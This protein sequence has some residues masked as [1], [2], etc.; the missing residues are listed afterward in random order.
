MRA[1]DRALDERLPGSTLYSKRPSRTF[2]AP[3]RSVSSPAPMSSSTF[4]R[5]TLSPPISIGSSRVGPVARFSTSQAVSRPSRRSPASRFESEAHSYRPLHPPYAAPGG[6]VPHYH[7]LT[8]PVRFLPLFFLLAAGAMRPASL[9][10]V[11]C[12]QHAPLTLRLGQ[13][14][15]LPRS[16]SNPTSSAVIFS[17]RMEANALFGP[18]HTI[19]DSIRVDAHSGVTLSEASVYTTHLRTPLGSAH[20]VISALTDRTGNTVVGTCDYNLNLV[21]PPGKQMGISVLQVRWLAQIPVR[22]CAIEGSPAATA[23]SG[24]LKLL[25]QV[26][27]TIWYPAAQI[28]FSSAIETGIPV[29][30]DPSPNDGSAKGDL[31]VAF[32]SGEP[33][34]AA[35]ACEAAWASQFPGKQGIPVVTARKFINSGLTLGVTPGPDTGLMTAS[36][37]AGS[38]KRGDDLCGY[39]L[40]V[41]ADD[42]VNAQR[43]PFSVVVDAS[44][45]TGSSDATRN[46]AHELGHNL[47]LGHGNGLDDN[48]DG[49]AAGGR[50]PLRYDEYCDPGW[51]LPPNFEE[52]AE[53]K[54]TVFVN[55]AQSGS[56]MFPSASCPNLQPLQVETARG[57]ALLM[58]GA[59]DGTPQRVNSQ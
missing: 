47:F 50:G 44:F 41:R 19:G 21:A 15:P 10:S 49:K 58:P 9:P 57:M 12:A 23:P 13:G 53:D 27:D 45:V 42:V 14:I 38:G 3:P 11:S 30:P 26:N 32:L 59:K 40:H 55:C 18:A 36:A 22:L 29:I 28:A 39:P 25:D 31:T 48:H 16:F 43:R 6:F 51:M 7:T 56:L 5:S 46:L 35:A 24:L 17:F 54:N 20:V 1:V 37:K 8:M 2:V 33:I 4:A 34:A 52:L